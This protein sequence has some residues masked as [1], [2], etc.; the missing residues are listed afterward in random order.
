[1]FLNCYKYLFIIF[2][3]EFNDCRPNPCLNGT[4]IDQDNTYACYCFDGYKGTHCDGKIF[5]LKISFLMF[6]ACVAYKFY[7]F[8]LVQSF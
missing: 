7:V 2:I 6:S 5:F 4:C 3:L 8:Q 1:M